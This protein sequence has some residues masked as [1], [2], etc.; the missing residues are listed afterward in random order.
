MCACSAPPLPRKSMITR[1]SIVESAVLGVALEI[2]PRLR[3]GRSY[4]LVHTLLSWQVSAPPRF[5]IDPQGSG[6]G[7]DLTFTFTQGV[8]PGPQLSFCQARNTNLNIGS[9][10][11]ENM[12]P[13]VSK[14]DHGRSTSHPKP[15]TQ[16]WPNLPLSLYTPSTLD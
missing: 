1:P 14:L 8:E 12:L 16:Q 2:R 15:H 10:S 7:S 4:V 9:G 11:C 6:S 5:R 13:H 3:C